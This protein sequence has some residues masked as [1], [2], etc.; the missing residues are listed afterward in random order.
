MF[1]KFEKSLLRWKEEAR[2]FASLEKELSRPDQPAKAGLALG[3]RFELG[4]NVAAD[5]FTREEWLWR[6][7]LP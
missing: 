4:E 1:R 3:G 2:L 6:D 7:Q 5:A